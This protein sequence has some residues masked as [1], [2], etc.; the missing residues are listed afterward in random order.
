M[1]NIVRS[2]YA[3]SSS[4]NTSEWDYTVRIVIMH[5]QNLL[6]MDDNG[7]SDPY[8]RFKLQNEKYKTKVK[9]KT[10]D[11]KWMETFSLHLFDHKSWQLDISVF[12]HNIAGRDD[13]MG[14]ASLDLSKLTIDRTHDLNV[15][16]EDEAGSLRILV[17]ITGAVSSTDHETSASTRDE[18]IRRYGLLNSLKNFNDV[19]WLQ[20]KVIRAHGLS[21]KDW[22]GKS[23][24][25]CTVEL[26]NTMLQSHTSYNTL[27]PEWNRVFTIPVKDIHS[28]LEVTVYDEDKDMK[29]EFI[30]KVAI[31]LI[32]IENGVQKWYGLKDKKLFSRVKGEVLLELDMV[33]NHVKAAFR[34]FNPREEPVLQEEPKFKISLFKRNVTRVRSIGSSLVSAKN[35]WQSLVDWDYPSKTLIAFVAFMVGVWNF[36]LY[37]LPLTLIMLFIWNLMVREIKGTSAADDMV[38]FE[39]RRSF[40]EYIDVV[41]SICCTIQEILG[42]IA[43]LGEAIKK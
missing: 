27:N 22:G 21:S 41:K 31:P 29:K 7:F 20:L 12:D 42:K 4:T 30:G 1:S 26:V 36:E 37:M 18:I 24:P 5:G 19:G 15:H 3:D 10:L 14:R 23:D 33:F 34:T 35:F 43:D 32:M 6:S 40:R 11:P 39:S 8:V 25:F 38:Y 2:D 13:F 9:N 28:V 17:T 16:L